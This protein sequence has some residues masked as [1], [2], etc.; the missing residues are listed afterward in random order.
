MAITAGTNLNSVPSSQKQTLSTNYLDFTGTTDNTW[1]QQYVPDLMEKE[2]EVFGQRTIS[3]FLSQVGAEESM[4]SDQ[5]VWSEQSRLHISV[6]GTVAVSGSTNGT[7]T[8]I[9][10][11]DGNI[12]GDGFTVA[13]H[14]VRTNDIVL[15]SS[16]GI[17]TQCLVVDADTAVIQVEP[18]DKADL[19]G[20]ATGASASRLLVVGVIPVPIDQTGSY[21]KIILL[22]FFIFFRP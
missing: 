2:A 12:A 14:G 22:F 9:S 17:V 3:G 13:N 4:T 19:T 1:A 18:Y 8:V 7:F 20:H 21:A 6:I 10:D 15:I 16:A 11:I 5:V